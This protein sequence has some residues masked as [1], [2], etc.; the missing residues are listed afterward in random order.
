MSSQ[1]QPDNNSDHRQTVLPSNPELSQRVDGRETPHTANAF[2]AHAQEALYER[3][4]GIVFQL[5]AQNEI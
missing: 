5:N 3:G 1:A 2:Y 4:K